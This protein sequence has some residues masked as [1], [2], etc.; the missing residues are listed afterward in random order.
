MEHSR[1]QLARYPTLLPGCAGSDILV[2]DTPLRRAGSQA[3]RLKERT[4][5]WNEG[6][7]Q[8]AQVGKGS[9]MKNRVT[10]GTLLSLRSW[11]GIRTWYQCFPD[12]IVR[13]L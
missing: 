1:C 6:P 5:T 8:D 2:D 13:P 7:E 11:H 10:G 12:L 9:G 4:I 3:G